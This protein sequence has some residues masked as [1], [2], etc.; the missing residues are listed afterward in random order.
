MSFSFNYLSETCT[1]YRRDEKCIL[2]FAEDLKER[3]ILV[4]PGVDGR[5]ILNRSLKNRV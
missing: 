5:I 2:I 4:D 3:D 1:M